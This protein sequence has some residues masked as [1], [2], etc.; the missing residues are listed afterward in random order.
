[1]M[2]TISSTDPI[3]TREWRMRVYPRV[4]LG[5]V[6]AA[7]VLV[8]MLGSGSS[9]VG[10]R[11]GGDFPAF[12]SAGSMVA[13][14]NVDQLYDLSAQ[15]VA[16]QDLLGPEGGF[17]M[18]PYAPHVALIYAPLSLLNY[19]VAY[20]VHTALMVAALIGALALIRPIIAVV[21]RW[22]ALSVA[23]AIGFYPILMA[24]GGGQ[25]TAVTLVLVAWMWRS[26]NDGRE[27][28]AGIAVALMMFRPQYALPLMALL[29]LGRHLRAVIW[30][31]AGMATTWMVGAVMM[32]PLWVTDWLQSVT[33]F[34]SA[35]ADTNAHNAVAVIGVLQA[36]LGADFT[37]GIAIG[38]ALSLGIAIVLAAA[39]WSGLVP[40]DLLVALTTTGMVLMSPHTMFY[41][42]GIV[43]IAVAVLVNR[44]PRRWPVIP[45][46][47]VAAMSQVAASTLGFSPFAPVVVALFLLA[48]VEAVSEERD[49]RELGLIAA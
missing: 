43:I 6:S 9:T 45:M 23:S 5:V 34:M 37:P 8:V 16:Q 22:F 36:A 32:G 1:M 48:L 41:D 33:P 4:F 17:L 18:F 42:S 19:R 39:W 7:F 21:D 2:Q 49:A 13:D 44:N 20:V 29:L 26:L 25:N 38:V 24:L 47:I 11:I 10:G 12:Y 3:T 15:K 31:A 27:V 40:L 14:G 28:P 30:A 35:D 46:L